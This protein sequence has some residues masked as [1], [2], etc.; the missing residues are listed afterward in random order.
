M[1]P[2]RLSIRWLTNMLHYIAISIVKRADQ[3]LAQHKCVKINKRLTACII[4]RATLVTAGLYIDLCVGAVTYLVPACTKRCVLR[5][6]QHM[7]PICFIYLC[8]YAHGLIQNMLAPIAHCKH[9]AQTCCQTC[10]T[11]NSMLVTRQDR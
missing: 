9:G 3:T 1:S 8:S 2:A 11:S 4:M 6:R 7:M 10:K 5:K